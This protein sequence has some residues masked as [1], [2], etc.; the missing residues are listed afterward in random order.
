MSTPYY[1]NA[2][3]LEADAGIRPRS[4][5]YRLYIVNRLLVCYFIAEIFML[6]YKFSCISN[7][8]YSVCL[9]SKLY[10]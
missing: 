10:M 3:D 7:R 2:D 8:P 5:K 4:F 1:T 6:Q 9:K